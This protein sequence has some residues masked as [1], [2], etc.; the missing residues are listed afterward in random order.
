MQELKETICQSRLEQEE[1]RKYLARAHGRE[2]EQRALL[3][4]L[5]LSETEAIQYLLMVS[6]D[7]AEQEGK[8]DESTQVREDDV[9]ESGFD[10]L[11]ASAAV[12]ASSS[13]SFLQPLPSTSSEDVQMSLLSAPDD[14]K[15]ISTDDVSHFPPVGP[16]LLG[17][18]PEFVESVWRTRKV[19]TAPSSRPLVWGAR[20]VV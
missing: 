19:V 2:K 7:E 3:E 5:G 15:P 11:T 4:S 8:K 10:Q 9:F 20:K 17:R 13:T 1:E 16:G 12:L 6:R 18:S 14:L